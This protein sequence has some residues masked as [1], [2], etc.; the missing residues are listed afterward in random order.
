MTVVDANSLCEREHSPIKFALWNVGLQEVGSRP[1][2]IYY[3]TLRTNNATDTIPAYSLTYSGAQTLIV[4]G[5]DD[6]HPDRVR[7]LEGND[8][9]IIG[10]EKKLF[11]CCKHFIFN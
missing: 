8:E 5:Q 6:R 1:Y 2:I 4:I 3:A 9:R 10:E 7:P 11:D